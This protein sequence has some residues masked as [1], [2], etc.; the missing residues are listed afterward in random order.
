MFSCK[1][2]W[3]WWRN[4]KSKIKSISHHTP[5]LELQKKSLNLSFAF[6]SFFLMRGRGS[7]K[8]LSRTSLINEFLNSKDVFIC[9]QLNSSESL[10]HTISPTK[11]NKIFLSEIFLPKQTLNYFIYLFLQK[12]IINWFS[13]YLSVDSVLPIANIWRDCFAKL[14]VT[15]VENIYMKNISQLKN[16]WSKF[17]RLSH[18]SCSTCA[19]HSERRQSLN[20]TNNCWLRVTRNLIENSFL[21][22]PFW[23]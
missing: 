8:F 12:A 9:F 7:S 14:C 5:E 23:V 2:L 4:T 10:M 16:I 18:T 20:D 1:L 11:Q 3:D 21:H 17:P 19:T 15:S 6:L 13:R 22:K